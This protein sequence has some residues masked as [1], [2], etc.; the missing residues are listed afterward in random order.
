MPDGRVVTAGSN[1]ARKTEELRI[2]VYWP[3]YLFRGSRP[4]LTLA[5]TTGTHGV[6]LAATTDDSALAS[7]GLVRPGVTTISY[8]D[9]QRLVDLPFTVD[10]TGALTLHLP[11]AN[12]APPGW[13]LVFP[14]SGTGVPSHAA[15]LHSPDR[16]RQ[17][18]EPSVQPAAGRAT[19]S[20][21]IDPRPPSASRDQRHVLL[22]QIDIGGCFTC[23]NPPQH[24][25][26]QPRVV[27][28]S[29]S[30]R[31][32]DPRIAGSPDHE[33]SAVD[34]RRPPAPALLPGPETVGKGMVSAVQSPTPPGSTLR[35]LAAA[36]RRMEG[37]GVL[38][39]PAQAL[40]RVLDAVLASPR[41]RS[42]LRGEPIGHALHPLL[43]DFPLGA[44][45]STTLLDL[46]G[47][48]SARRAATGLLGFGVT[49]ALPTVLTGLAEWRE[50]TGPARRVG[51]VHAA[52][53]STALGLYSSS[54]MARLRG[55]H[56][57]AVVLGVAGGLVATVGGYL[58][59]HLSLVL[60]VAT[61]DPALVA[62]VED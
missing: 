14:V 36:I 6:T 46:F 10:P 1:P 40:R 56:T 13:Y 48:R 49:A 43:T 29:T 16:V 54:L 59:G 22:H 30:L 3:P 42:A 53:N 24:W 23:G 39:R 34:F 52:V 61:A 60:K 5:A 11:T 8:D 17:G 41:A 28:G 32:E 58:G 31:R 57:T 7:V 55:R 38:D 18:D 25:S 45:L 21:S 20:Q 62:L 12:L 50:A 37:A 15:W 2:E 19:T 9:D 33:G 26:G 51:V 44:W 27:E 35:P 47:G 4:R